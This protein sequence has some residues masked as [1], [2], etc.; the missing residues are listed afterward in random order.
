MTRS[1]TRAATLG[2]ATLMLAVSATANLAQLRLDRNQERVTLKAVDLDPPLIAYL[3][4]R[5]GDPPRPAIV[6]MH[7]CSGLLNPQGRIFGLY[8]AWAR[9]LV[10][11]GYVVLI[12]DSASPRGFGQ[13][14]NDGPQRRAMWRDRAKDAYAGLAFLQEQPFVQGDRVALM[15]W[16]QGGGVVL[17]AINDKSIGRPSQLA[18]DF[19]AAVSF[20]PGLCNER[21]QSKP[22]TLVEPR[23]WTTRVPLLVLFGEADVW[24]PIAP[25]DDFIQ[26]AKARGNPVELKSYA[27]V[28]HG[29]DAPNQRRLELPA[30]KLE[31]GTIPVIGTDKDARE[32]AL[33]RVPAFLEQHLAR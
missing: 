17:L 14:C 33:V 1:I 24:T 7:G 31:D 19:R 6:M 25:C 15:G 8:Q 4:R 16:S 2:L 10:A 26:A 32:D 22:F 5:V 13:T 23:S 18:H 12:V 9:S 21:Y 30:Y 3:S 27:D 20:Y 11:K 28:V 29:F